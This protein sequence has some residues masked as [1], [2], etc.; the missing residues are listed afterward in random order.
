MLF[1]SKEIMGHLKLEYF[2]VKYPLIPSTLEFMTQIL[3][4][5]NYN[6]MLK[7]FRY[8]VHSLASLSSHAGAPSITNFL[9]NHQSQTL[10]CISSGGPATTVSW[11]KNGRQIGTD[12]AQ[13]S[14]T[15][16]VMQTSS[17]TYLNNLVFR[18][19]EIAGNYSCTVSNA[20]GIASSMTSIVLHSKPIK[21]M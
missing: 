11:M 19:F 15:Q 12:G 2:T 7:F 6:W 13:F 17:T 21:L 14:Q 16:I 5:H 1:V 20:R 10:T 3:V 8:P 4:L 18:T 9:F